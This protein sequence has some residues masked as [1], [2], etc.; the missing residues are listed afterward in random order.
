MDREHHSAEEGEAIEISCFQEE[1]AP[2]QATILQYN[3]L[4]G[5]LFSLD[6]YL[7]LVQQ[8]NNNIT[9]NN[10][11]YVDSNANSNTN[12]N[13]LL[14]NSN[15][16]MSSD[17]THLKR[18]ISMTS[19]K[20]LTITDDWESVEN[21]MITV[22]SPNNNTPTGNSK[23]GKSLLSIL[24]K[25]KT[26]TTSPGIALKDHLIVE[27]VAD[28][29][30]SLSVG[31]EVLNKLKTKTNSS[32]SMTNL[33]Q[34]DSDELP[35]FLQHQ[36]S[37][38][39]SLLSLIKNNKTN[40]TGIDTTTATIAI[41]TTAAASTVSMKDSSNNSKLTTITPLKE[42]KDKQGSDLETK[43]KKLRQY[44]EES[45]SVNNTISIGAELSTDNVSNI[46]EILV[47]IEK[48]MV[49]KDG[50]EA[51][52]T[53]KSKKSNS[54]ELTQA[55]V[56]KIVETETKKVIDAALTSNK[57]KEEVSSPY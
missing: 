50:F 13:S 4:F 45:K 22:T 44:K 8:Q 17:H 7:K 56:K 29:P 55:N 18:E 39:S 25:S 10:D 51:M 49:T 27:E 43:I 23:K 32:N 1:A 33:V 15:T 57:W 54:N 48:N 30:T 16:I 3:A 38:N 37:T 28:K 41:A 20:D 31:K 2:D 5:N 9:D 19:P 52:F 34:P 11:M 40:G 53:E 12:L 14:G 26:S 35:S 47:N 6:K 24:G 46:E 36:P 21:K 42:E